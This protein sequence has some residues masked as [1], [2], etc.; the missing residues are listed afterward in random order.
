MSLRHANFFIT[1]KLIYSEADV[2]GVVQARS[3]C[4]ASIVTRNPPNSVIRFGANLGNSIFSKADGTSSTWPRGA[5][6]LLCRR[7]LLLEVLI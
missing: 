2:G 7:L 3:G 5:K 6:V 4:W 1:S